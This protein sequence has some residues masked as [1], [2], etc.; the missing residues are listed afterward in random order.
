MVSNNTRESFL[1]ASFLAGS[2]WGSLFVVWCMALE[3]K[4][5]L[6]THSYGTGWLSGWMD[7][8]MD[9]KYQGVMISM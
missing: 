8:W 7:G 1:M 2:T 5:D 6:F 4:W 3:G 9:G